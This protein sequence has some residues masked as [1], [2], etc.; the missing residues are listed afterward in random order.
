MKP[1]I[2]KIR[3]E[4]LP[5]SELGKACDY[6]LGQWT[7]LE[8]FLKDGTVEIDN[9]WCENGMRPM[10]LGVKNWLHIGSELAGP[11]VAAI[12]SILET[13]RRLGMNTREY[14]QDVLPIL[15]TWP[16]TRVA[17]LRPAAWKSR[18]NK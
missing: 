12:V 8:E 11:K 6:A 16:I 18:Q 2:L 9:N 3:Q 5:Q 13:C 10:K 1:K 15:P 17:E 7:R 14:L 4:V